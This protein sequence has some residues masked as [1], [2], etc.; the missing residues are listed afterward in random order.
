MGRADIYSE[1]I[2]SYFIEW[3]VVHTRMRYCSQNRE[4]GISDC[5]QNQDGH[6]VKH[7]DESCVKREV[8]ANDSVHADGDH[9]NV[10]DDDDEDEDK[11]W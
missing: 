2:Y 6:R 11:S 10:D 9:G 5:E 4:I 1:L 3:T 7:F 8:E